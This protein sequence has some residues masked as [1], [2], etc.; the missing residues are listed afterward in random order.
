MFLDGCQWSTFVGLLVASLWYN[1][2]DDDFT[3]DISM[4]ASSD[5]PAII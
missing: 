3:M 5:A 4:N 2:D 1:D